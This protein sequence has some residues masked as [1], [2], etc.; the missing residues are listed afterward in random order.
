[1]ILNT[2]PIILNIM[3]DIISLCKRR[4]FIFTSS[5]IYGGYAGFFDYGPLG[6]EMKHNIT[7]I[8]WRKM[9]HGRDNMV[10][11]DCEYNCRMYSKIYS[12]SS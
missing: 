7:N 4:G 5:E 2:F 12:S 11:L 6:V 8:W 10:D 9:I 1:M 3:D